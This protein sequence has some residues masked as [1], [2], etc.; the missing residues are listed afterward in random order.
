MLTIL[1]PD[2]AV[3]AV[4]G[5]KRRCVK[6]AVRAL[7]Q[8]GRC[9]VC[10]AGHSEESRLQFHHLL[11]FLTQETPKRFDIGSARAHT[12]TAVR[13]ELNRTALLCQPCHKGVHAGLLS[14]A[15]LE[16]ITPPDIVPYVVQ[17]A[18]GGGP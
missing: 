12:P 11:R 3:A 14:D 5:W 18:E 17:G 6:A 15:H 2:P 7:R 13:R 9:A 10:N 4:R 16:P 1:R 8:N